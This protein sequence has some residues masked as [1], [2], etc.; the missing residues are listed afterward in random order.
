MTAGQPKKNWTN[1]SNSS[2]QAESSPHDEAT[3]KTTHKAVKAEDVAAEF[4]VSAMTIK[5]ARVV[6]QQG[7]PEII[8]AHL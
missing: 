7:S 8:A 6:K 1:L 5:D 4:N 2:D 3:K